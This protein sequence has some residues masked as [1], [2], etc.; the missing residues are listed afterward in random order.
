[1]PVPDSPYEAGDHYY[2]S[3]LPP[4]FPI[5]KA[6]NPNLSR[7]SARMISARGQSLVRRKYPGVALQAWQA[8]LLRG[9]FPYGV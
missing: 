3:T 5:K 8:L 4:C 1:M 2:N 6:E 7:F 9:S